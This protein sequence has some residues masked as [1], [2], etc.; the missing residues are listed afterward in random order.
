MD[1]AIGHGNWNGCR[2]GA[3]YAALLLLLGAKQG[4]DAYLAG[5]LLPS[6]LARHHAQNRDLADVL[7]PAAGL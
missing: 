2:F 6:S 7:P 4:Q 5:Q 3:I 1:M